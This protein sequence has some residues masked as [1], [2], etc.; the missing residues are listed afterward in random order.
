MSDNYTKIDDI[1]YISQ[2]LETSWVTNPKEHHIGLQFLLEIADDLIEQLTIEMN[3]LHDCKLPS[4]YWHI[5]L[6]PWLM[7]FLGFMY[8]RFRLVEG[9]EHHLDSNQIFFKK[10]ERI[11][12]KNT[13]ESLKLV[14]TDQFNSQI[15]Y[16]IYCFKKM[17]VPKQS[18]I[19]E[20]RHG[21]TKGLNFSTAPV[22]GDNNNIKKLILNNLAKLVLSKKSIGAS[23]GAIPIK[24]QIKLSLSGVK[25]LIPIYPYIDGVEHYPYLINTNF[26]NAKLNNNYS[27]NQFLNFLNWNLK[28]YLPVCFVEG[29]NKLRYLSKRYGRAPRAIIIG[30]EMYSRSE[31]FMHWSATNSLSG[32]KLV[33]MQHG[34][35]YG[36]EFRSEKTF[37]EINAYD[38]FYT[39]GW[40]WHQFKKNSTTRLKPMPSMFLTNTKNPSKNLVDKTRILFTVTSIKANVRRLD[41]SGMNPYI[42]TNYFADQLKFY[43]TLSTFYQEQVSVRLYKDDLK[44]RYSDRWQR[45]FSNVQF[46]KNINFNTSLNEAKLYVGDCLQTTWIEALFVNKPFILF[47]SPGLY[48]FTPEYEELVKKLMSVNV[49][50]YSPEGA[51]KFINNNY[52]KIDEWWMSNKVQDVILKVRDELAWSPQNSQELWI[53]ELN[54]FHG[55][56]QIDY[57]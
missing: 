6:G 47:V 52:F 44:N 57:N 41:C 14:E 7:Q 50:Y 20:E 16:D 29:Y 17:F 4:R 19:Y 46:D 10:F 21:P 34:G 11:V 26:R 15:L 27:D 5:I 56:K 8:D 39:W 22:F 1:I 25:K 43:G 55:Y 32:T 36:M 2:K 30:T 12:P 33:S 24:F 9:I 35:N 51:A 3:S 54:R 40:N 23:I 18:L 49:F 31:S 45:K 37:I 28:K 48:D 42:N 38:N 13:Y 53:K